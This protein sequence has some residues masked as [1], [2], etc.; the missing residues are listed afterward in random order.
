M[1]ITKQ[2]LPDIAAAF[3]AS[4]KTDRIFFDDKL[5]GFGI[6]FRQG[7][8][9]QSYVVQYERGGEQRRLTLEG[10]AAIIDPDDARKWAK[11]QLAKVTLGG[12]PGGDKA[13]ARAKAKITLL[14]GGA[15]VSRREAGESA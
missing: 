14:S 11:Q 3:A 5:P 9:R 13:T 2:N 7:S 6:R 4:G 10:S 8:K 15:A 12:D 1:K